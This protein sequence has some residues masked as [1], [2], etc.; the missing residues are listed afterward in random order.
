[1]DVYL[2]IRDVL[3]SFLLAPR[4]RFDYSPCYDRL[5][6]SLGR[7]FL[8]SKYCCRGSCN[9]LLCL[10][11]HTD[12]DTIYTNKLHAH[13]YKMHRDIF[14]SNHLSNIIKARIRNMP[15]PHE[16]P[17]ISMPSIDSGGCTRVLQKANGALKHGLKRIRREAPAEL[18]QRKGFFS[19]C[20]KSFGNRKFLSHKT[21]VYALQ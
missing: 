5:W 11:I 9:T 3:Y 20:C 14:F 8:R 15:T 2:S 21:G 6:Y 16:Q 19:C 18:K 4:L 17:L 7:D 1:M 10:K 12:R 13:V